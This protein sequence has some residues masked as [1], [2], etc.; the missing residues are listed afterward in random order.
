MG[1]ILNLVFD[2]WKEDGTPLPNLNH[3]NSDGEKLILPFY[4]FVLKPSDIKLNLCKPSDVS[5][6]G[7]YYY[8]IHFNES[9]YDG[10]NWE[11]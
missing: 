9:L 4:I 8:F 1:H 7:L 2:N 6:D 3:L 11:I 10:K 5:D